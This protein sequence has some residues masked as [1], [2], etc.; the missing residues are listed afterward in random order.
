MREEDNGWWC[1]VGGPGCQRPTPGHYE[2]GRHWRDR[3]FFVCEACHT[4]RSEEHTS[5]AQPP[6][7]PPVQPMNA[8]TNWIVQI[9]QV[10]IPNPCAS[11]RPR[12][13]CAVREH[14]RQAALLEAAERILTQENRWY[15]DARA[16]GCERPKAGPPYLLGK[17]WRGDYTFFVCDACYTAGHSKGRRLFEQTVARQEQLALDKAR[18]ALSTGVRFE[19]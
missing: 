10:Q 13:A 1:N 7:R 16:E 18:L 5:V 9:S 19:I 11:P 2:P 8:L 6:A 12:A 4:E 17:H 14:D 15:C 3:S